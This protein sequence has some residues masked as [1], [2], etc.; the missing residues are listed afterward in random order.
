MAVFKTDR[1]RG[2]SRLS[3]DQ[4][5]AFLTDLPCKR[6][7]DAMQFVASLA[8]LCTRFGIDFMLSFA[9]NCEESD[10]FRHK[11]WLDR[12]NPM[13]IGVTG[14]PVE[15]AASPTFAN[16]RDAAAAYMV[17]LLVYVGT[18]SIDEES[19]VAAF[20]YLDPH[21]QNV[22]D[23]GWQ[24]KVVVVDDVSGRWATDKE[25]GQ[26]VAD[27][28]NEI[29]PAVPNQGDV[30]VSPALNMTKG[31]IPMPDMIQA[32]VDVSK[33]RV[34]MSC[35]GY[36]WLGYRPDTPEFLVVHRAQC[37]P[38]ASNEAY[39][40]EACCPALTDLEVNCVTGQMK[41]FVDRGNTPSGW[42]NGVVNAPYGDALKWLNQ[43]G[44]D[45]NTV[46]RDGE[47]CEVS[48]YFIQPGAPEITHEDDVSD[49]AI[50]QLAN[51]FA[52]R[53]HDKGIPWYDFPIIVA[54]GGRSYI[55]N[56]EEW[57]SGTGKICGGHLVLQPLVVNV[58]IPRA[59]VIMKAA[60]TESAP[61]PTPKPEAYAA[62]KVPAWIT[63]NTIANAT[64]DVENGK[65]VAHFVEHKWTATRDTR[66][67]QVAAMNAKKVGPD[68]KKGEQFIGHFIV[69]AADGHDYI[70]TKGGTRFL[71]SDM[72]E[73]IVVSVNA[74]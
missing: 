43:N 37:P 23:A 64:D 72:T 31:L 40:D 27:R 11:W 52:S 51:W 65:I 58:I 66:R 24:G 3:A 61:V 4:A 29:F 22:I 62:A 42:A 45:L 73:T 44:W 68:L 59:Q 17:H 70:F 48:G 57:T 35:R 6:L 39:F 56:H 47:A 9:D 46:N 19:F 8:A 67:R 49:L 74:N 54:E 69:T 53:G 13:N 12:L 50:E 60:Q 41:R 20:K 2:P 33:R 25:K 71:M 30:P 10:N 32:I 5:I 1:W 18:R 38:E 26:S 14:D 63:D 28:A 15:N 36:D 16:A 7:S 21:Y 34:D 55:T